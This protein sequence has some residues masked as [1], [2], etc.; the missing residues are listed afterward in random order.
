[1]PTIADKSNIK[2][3]TKVIRGRDWGWGNQDHHNGVPS[4][5]EVIPDSSYFPQREGK[6]WVK[7]RWGC[8]FCSGSYR[9]GINDK[10]DL[11][12]YEPEQKPETPTTKFK[13]GDVVKLVNTNVDP[14]YWKGI[15]EVK[16]ENLKNRL[17][18]IKYV[19]GYANCKGL[20]FEGDFVGCGC[21]YPEV[22]FELAHTK[23]AETKSIEEEKPISTY[24]LTV[25]MDL[26]CRAL[27]A[28]QQ[29]G[30]NRCSMSS[31]SSLKWHKNNSK[32][33][34]NRKIKGFKEIHGVVGFLISGTSEVHHRA[35]GFKEFLEDYYKK[36]R[37]QT[38]KIDFPLT[39][40]EAFQNV[41]EVPIKLGKVTDIAPYPDVQIRIKPKKKKP[42]I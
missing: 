5:G 1:M 28:W 16:L 30:D 36:E 22:C 31:G 3:G 6:E 8:G 13:V 25:G 17:L 35:E 11:Y 37:L 14:K 12:L 39:E 7:V 27:E 15:G 4:V 33:I 24:G 10:F 34:H 32:F 42:T 26:P 18:E 41:Q 9:I 29:A 20:M 21:I 2:I 40:K 23:D 19:E 38:A